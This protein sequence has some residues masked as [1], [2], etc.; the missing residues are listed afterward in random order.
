MCVARLRPKDPGNKAEGN[1]DD[2]VSDEDLKLTPA[3]LREALRTKIG[4]RNPKKMARRWRQAQT[5]K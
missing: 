5:R 1:S 3:D 4:G 2:L